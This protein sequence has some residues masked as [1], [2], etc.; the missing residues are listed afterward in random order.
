[1]KYVFTMLAVAMLMLC[2]TQESQAQ[3]G[4]RGGGYGWG[5]YGQFQGGYGGYGHMGYGHGG[6]GHV[7]YGHG[8]YYHPHCGHHCY[9]GFQRHYYNVPM[10][11]PPAYQAGPPTAAV[12]Y[13]YYT[14]RGPRD[15]L[16]DDPPSLGP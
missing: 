10:I 4:F 11:P 2:A 3:K 1:M 5:G 15:F 16:M 13:P 12:T 6:H 7:G 8:G 14:V 9:H